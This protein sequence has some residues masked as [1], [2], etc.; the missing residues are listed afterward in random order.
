MTVDIIPS[1]GLCEGEYHVLDLEACANAENYDSVGTCRVQEAFPPERLT[2]PVNEGSVEI[3]RSGILEERKDNEDKNSGPEEDMLS[4]M[5]HY[6]VPREAV[7]NTG[8]AATSER[9][10]QD[11]DVQKQRQDKWVLRGAT[12]RKRMYSPQ[13]CHDIPPVLAKEIDIQ[14]IALTNLV[15]MT[16]DK[17]AGGNSS[18]KSKPNSYALR[19]VSFEDDE[20]ANKTIMKRRSMALRHVRRTRC[21]SIDWCLFPRP[22]SSTAALCRHAFLVR[23]LPASTSTST[24]AFAGTRQRA[25]GSGATLTRAG[26]ETAKW[27]SLCMDMATNMCAVM[28]NTE[29]A[30]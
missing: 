13:T 28:G 21:I 23:S 27:Q 24:M 30:E 9:T 14:P 18:K 3:M 16:A 6:V 7:H 1:G 17:R 11:Q 22:F 10:G 5:P 12:P 25:E 15:M 2:F 20:E 29:T 19:F 26:R 8:G 4:Q